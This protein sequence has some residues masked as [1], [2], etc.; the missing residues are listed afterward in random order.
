VFRGVVTYLLNRNLG[1]AI[2][3]DYETDIAGVEETHLL[4][5]I[6]WRDVFFRYVCD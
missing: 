6:E 4:P 1:D 5:A 2:Q 3:D